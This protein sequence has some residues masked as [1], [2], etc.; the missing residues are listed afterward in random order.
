MK[1]VAMRPALIIMFFACNLVPDVPTNVSLVAVSSAQLQLSWETPS[2]RN[3]IIS[4]YYITWKIVRNDTNHTVDGHIKTAEVKETINIKK[5]SF[6]I[7]ELGK[8]YLFSASYL[9]QSS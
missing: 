3:G 2:H 7:S 9:K 8:H 5:K 1:I 4:V 6:E